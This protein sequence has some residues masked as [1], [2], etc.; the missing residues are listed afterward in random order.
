MKLGVIG[1]I[2]FDFNVGRKGFIREDR[3]NSFVD[4]TISPGGPASNAAYLLSHYGNYVDLYGEIGNDA[5]GD[6]VYK[7]MEKENVN[8]KHISIN[9]EKATP[10]SFIINNEIDKTRTICTVR[11]PKDY[12]EATIKNINYEKDY[13]YILTDGKYYEESIRLIE[14]NPSAISIIDAGRVS[15]EMLMLCNFADIIICSTAFANEIVERDIGDNEEEN[16][17]IYKDLK[18]YFPFADKLVITIGSKGYIC[19]KDGEILIMPAHQPGKEVIDTTGAGDIFHGAFTHALA[20]NYSFH[21]SLEFANITASLST[22]KKGGRYSITELY[23]VE[24]IMKNK[25]KTLRKK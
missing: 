4:S 2:T 15:S 17:A 22:T 19:E 20:N 24:E 10:F 13:D 5:F 8:I 23:E 21:E 9:E 12:K 1:N 16:I 25:P 7:Q 6:F 3:R 14:S 18:S 11:D